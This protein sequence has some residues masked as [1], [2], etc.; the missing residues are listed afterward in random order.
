M[1]APA[2][3]R[4]RA[5]SRLARNIALRLA[6]V[7]LILLVLSFLT[8]TLLY[9][10]PGDLVKNLL[11]NRP[12]TPDAIA[13]VRAQYQLDDPFLVRYIDW[14]FSALRGDFGISIRMQQPVTDVIASRL[15]V[16]LT[17]IGF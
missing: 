11:G 7:L 10:A 15:S 1:P 6:S 17:L 3:G 13:A 16:T 12:S 9:L 5:R 14:L 8:F 4:T 2:T